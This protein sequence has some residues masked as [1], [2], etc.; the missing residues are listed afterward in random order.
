MNDTHKVHK[1]AYYKVV[2]V[3][4][5]T[6]VLPLPVSAA[7]RKQLNHVKPGG[8]VGAHA[9]NTTATT[10]DPGSQTPHHE[11]VSSAKD[12]GNGL[13]LDVSGKPEK[14]QDHHQCFCQTR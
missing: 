8:G 10:A 14:H 7:C 1:T 12:Q 6:P 5:P 2:C 3:F 9:H 11:N 4:L 13:S